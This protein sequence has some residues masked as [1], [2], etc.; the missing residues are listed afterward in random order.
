MFK[1]KLVSVLGLTIA[2]AA[3]AA[4]AGDDVK[5]AKVGDQAPDFKLTDIAGTEH[6][7]KDHA[8]KI[9]VLEWVNPGC[10]VCKAAHQDGRIP[11]MIK[12]LKAEGVVYLA[13]NSTWN[14]TAED[15][16]AA[17][18]KYG[19]EYD[20]LLDNDGVVGKSFGA[21]T[22]PHLY[23][24]DTKGV[25]R[26]QGALDN[27]GP[28]GKVKEGETVTNYALNAVKQIKAGETVTPDSTQ[29]YGCSVKYAKG[30]S[31]EKAGS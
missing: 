3:A 8:G 23:V 24:I 30:K 5:A 11:N 13:V 18:K 15:N 17:L 19:I 14:T 12:E 27:V 31:G 28:S 4:F 7:L 2:V 16:A 6:S 10:P 25:L 29:P 22:T 9:V 21:K 20:V 26:Y 1:S